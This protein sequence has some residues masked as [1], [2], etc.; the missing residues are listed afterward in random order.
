[1]KLS[2]TIEIEKEALLDMPYQ[3][4]ERVTYIKDISPKTLAN[5]CE[6]NGIELS[7]DKIEDKLTATIPVG[8]CSNIVLLSNK[9]NINVSWNV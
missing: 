3:R 8:L 4:V 5:Y 1:M 9:V 7:I 6:E 2:E